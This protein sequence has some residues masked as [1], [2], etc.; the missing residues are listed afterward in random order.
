MSEAVSSGSWDPY[1]MRA[2]LLALNHGGRIFHMEERGDVIVAVAHYSDPGAIG[3]ELRTFEYCVTLLP[4]SR[5][6]THHT[7][8]RLGAPADTVLS[9]G[10]SMTGVT[11]PVDAVLA[12]G[13]WSKRASWVRRVFGGR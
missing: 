12:E 6:F 4:E 11:H 9:R 5:Q 10:F 8:D 13:G 3:I 2:A 7:V 1:E